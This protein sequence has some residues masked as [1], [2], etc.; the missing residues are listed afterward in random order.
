MSRQHD[1][2]SHRKIENG[3]AQKI[4]KY[5]SMIVEFLAKALSLSDSNLS[6]WQ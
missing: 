3:V 6:N 2:V 5:F 1:H 4:Y